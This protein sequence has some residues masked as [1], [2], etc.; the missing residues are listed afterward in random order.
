MKSLSCLLACTVALYQG[1]DVRL[2]ENLRDA[3]VDHL[4]VPPGHEPPDSL[5]LALE[6]A[7]V[8]IL[9]AGPETEVIDNGLWPGL[10]ANIVSDQQ[11]DIGFAAATAEPWVNENGWILLHA[12]GVAPRKR[13]VLTYSPPKDLAP[14]IGANALAIAE[15]AVFGG[16]YAVPAS[17]LAESATPRGRAHRRRTIAQLKFIA[18]HPDWFSGDIQSTVDVLTDNLAP[19]REI[20]NLL[21]RRNLS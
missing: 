19:V 1:N 21:V 11:R 4:L 18:D 13:T 12:R 8:A 3:Y 20:M 9:R 7:G 17:A 10:R 16:A 6:S 14:K 5:K 2:L 15:A